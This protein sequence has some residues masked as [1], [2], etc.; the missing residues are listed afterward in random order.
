MNLS[1]SG[2]DLAGTS[3]ARKWNGHAGA[4]YYDTDLRELMVFDE[5]IAGGIWL[6]ASGKA[7]YKASS[8]RCLFDDFKAGT[9]DPRWVTAEGNDDLAA[10]PA[11]VAGAYNGEL[12]LVTGD[13]G[14]T[15]AHDASCWAGP[16]LEWECEEGQITLEFRA[17]L[18]AITTVAF[19]LGLTDVLPSTTL[20]MPAT[21]SG[22]TYTTTATDAVGFLFDTAATTDTIRCVG[23]K[24]DTDATHVDSAVEP[25]AATYATYK[26]V[27]SAA[28]VAKFYINGTLVGTVADAVSVGVDLVP[29]AI[30]VPRTTSSRTLT[31]DWVAGK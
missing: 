22:T 21:L 30:A 12:A 3:A 4:T 20:E 25:V 18:S 10:L 28:G 16:A 27:L 8:P 7:L 19:F 29:I 5:N 13:A 31:L 23:V 2:I 11:L 14:D 9:L 6:P 24:A 1:Q 26:I 15:V 17:K